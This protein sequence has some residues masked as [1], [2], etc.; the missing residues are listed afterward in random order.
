VQDRIR[1]ALKGRSDEQAA[2]LDA[3][4]WCSFV[5]LQM[6]VKILQRIISPDSL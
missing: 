3:Q 6:Y 4:P 1:L 2:L 5:E